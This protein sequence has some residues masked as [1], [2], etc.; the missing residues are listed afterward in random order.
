M[1][2]KE[3]FCNFFIFPRNIDILNIFSYFIYVWPI[4][5][6][7]LYSECKFLYFLLFPTLTI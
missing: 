5:Q 2:K 1:N 4:L 3:I 7:K 6:F